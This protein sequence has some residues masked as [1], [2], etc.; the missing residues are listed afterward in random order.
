MKENAT[1]LTWM[2]AL[3]MMVFVLA[4]TGCTKSFLDRDP[5]IGSSAGNFYQ[6]AEDA[7]AATIACYA[8]LQVEISDG[9]HFRWYFGDIVS[10]D[11]DKGG[12]GD[13][14]EPDL[15][16]FENFQGDPSSG[17]VL[18]EWKTAYKGITYCNIALENIPGIEMDEFQKLAYLG[19]A[20]FLRAYWYFNLVTTFGGVPLVTKTLAPSEYAQP[21]ATA[22][23]V[24][25]QIVADLEEA[26]ANLPEKSAYGTSQTGRATRG[27]ANAL[28]A[29][30]HLYQGNWADCRTR[31]EEVVG[32]GE[33]F[34]DPNYGNIFTEGGENGPGSIW[35]IQYANNSGGNWGAQFWSEGTYT[36][37]FQR[38][39]GTFSGYGF[40]LPT[41]AFVD[42]FEVWEEQIGPDLIEKVDPRLGYTVYQLGDNAS[43]WG[44]ITEDATG[45]PNPYYARKY[46]NPAA[47]LAPFGD[48]NPNGGSND[49]VIRLADV[50]LMHAEAC[51]QLGDDA[52]AIASLNM[53]RTRAAVP[54]IQEGS[55]SGQ[56]LL[57]AIWHERR[58]ELGL[59]GHRFFDLVRQGRAAEVLEGFVPGKSE[60]FPIPT[61]EITLS[62]GQLTQ[63]PGY[64]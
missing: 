26:A 23:E 39:R 47:E 42:E 54:L 33:Y 9:A 52:T 51:Q 37:V 28:L 8:P 60:L 49:R 35:E 3:T 64:E 16:E 57:D 27:A 59:E 18:G 40:N 14:D 38:A 30:A 13:T 45:M 32:S 63:N 10:D 34:L 4:S 21:R 55:V 19:E 11:S 2:G 46:F 15:L 24:W 36:N 7:E 53:V 29:K 62:N 5:Y 31:C 12:S 1:T 22:D 6:S 20:Q 58:V 25:A 50:L 41:Q 43:D 48:P 44:E 56:A 17:I 61:A